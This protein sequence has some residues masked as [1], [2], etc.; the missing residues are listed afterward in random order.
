MA[1]SQPQ[2]AYYPYLKPQQHQQQQ[3]LYP[4]LP[5][6]LMQMPARRQ[7]LHSSDL[8][9]SSQPQYLPLPSPSQNNGVYPGQ[10]QGSGCGDGDGWPNN[11][12]PGDARGSMSG[13]RGEMADR[14]WDGNYMDSG[15]G[16]TRAG[17]SGSGVR[18]HWS[19]GNSGGAASKIIPTSAESATVPVAT[20]LQGAQGFTFSGNPILTNIGTNTGNLTTVNNYGGTHG[21]EKLERFV[22]FAALHDSAEQDP[23]RRCHPGTRN[24][25]LRQLRDWFNNP[26]ATDPIIWLHGPAGAGKSA[27]AQ[28]IAHEYRE[29]GLAATFFF[30]RSDAER[31]DGNRLFPTIAWQLAFSIPAI[32]DFI[33]HALD[34]T[35]HLPRK[36]V[37]TQFEQLVSHPFQAL[38]NIASQ[39]PRFAPVVIIDGVDE[40]SDE[41]LQRRFLTVIGDALKDP[42][43]ILRFIICS[44]PEARIEETLGQFKDSTLQI[45]LATLDDSHCDIEK[46]LVDQLSA[47]ASKRSLDP[48]WP[49]QEII[50]EIVFQSSGNFILPS[51]L[52]RFVSDEDYSPESQLDIV[53]KLKPHEN[54]SPFALLDEL[55]LEV[56]K[57]PPDQDFLKTF[58]AL[59]VGRSSID[60]DDLH[61]DDATLMNISEKDLR[62]KLRKMRSLLKFKPF[63]DV[64]HKSFLDFLQDPSRSGQYHISKQAGLKRYLELVVGSVVLH[65]SMVIEQPNR[66]ETCHFNP[67]FK[68][69]VDYYPP[70]I[71]L[72]VED[73]QSVLTPLLDLQDK[74]LNT[75]KPRP[76]RVTQ[77]MR[78]LLLHLV[79]LQG[80]SHHIAATHVPEPNKNETV[81]RWISGPVTEATQNIPGTD[82]DSCLSALLSCLQKMNSIMVVDG[83][84]IDHMSS[85]LAFDYA[86]TA[87]RVRS[88]SDAQKL[89]DL[90]DL[91]RH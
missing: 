19:G 80:K 47:I 16:G 8:P 71:V 65:V 64:Y 49:G 51:T 52:I 34:R 5:Q 43:A 56:L 54:A 59:F 38:N 73:W 31:N 15:G 20:Q 61:E 41:Q 53:R 1:S 2:Q 70:K 77:I 63:I 89:I 3:H 18:A 45:D 66:H 11:V 46:Y 21:L 75:S 39:M 4:T 50:Q 83:A 33:V 35:P 79:V 37:E 84:I 72:P 27:I 55:Y 67:T 17:R 90:I 78:D 12:Q 23:D 57:R 91:V 74:I 68:S 81:T 86:E 44:R 69:I 26:D 28:T 62:T 88:I 24:T 30:Y 76:C 40:C 22:S 13:N 60:Q 48:T 87:A 7:Q 25:V 32:K 85:L 9:P 6:H 10:S 42:R 29:R 36:D 58:L 82:L 14:D